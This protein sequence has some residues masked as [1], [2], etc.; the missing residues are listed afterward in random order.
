M[1]IDVAIPPLAIQLSH[2]PPMMA[3]LAGIDWVLKWLVNINDSGTTVDS[4][5]KRS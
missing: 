1:L 5:V 3:F 2:L 4:L